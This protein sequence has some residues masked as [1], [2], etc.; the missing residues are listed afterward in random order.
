MRKQL[1]REVMQQVAQQTLVACQILFVARVVVVLP[2]LKNVKV[3]KLRSRYFCF[4]AAKAA[5]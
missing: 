2:K 4:R 3:A 5:L 1:R